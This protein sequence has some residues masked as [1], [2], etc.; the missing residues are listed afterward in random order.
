MKSL[1]RVWA[2]GSI[3]KEV[4]WFVYNRLLGPSTLSLGIRA[5]FYLQMQGMHFSH[6]RFISRFQ[7]DRKVGQGVLLA[8]AIS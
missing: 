5:S 3:D 2:W 8:L 7:G 4:T 1:K 6:R